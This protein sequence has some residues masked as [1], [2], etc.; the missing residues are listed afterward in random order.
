MI[1][2][3]YI[4]YR[5]VIKCLD[6]FFFF[7]KQH[8]LF[9]IYIYIYIYMRIRFCYI[10]HFIYLKVILESHSNK[11]SYLKVIVVIKDIYK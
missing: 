8:M 11:K 7:E 2:V 6:N 10:N 4:K 5:N 3:Y 1:K 9:Y